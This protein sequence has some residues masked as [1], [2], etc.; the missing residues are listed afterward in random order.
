[1]SREYLR[2]WNATKK[3]KGELY[4][5][6]A[7]ILP[8]DREPKPGRKLKKMT[9]SY[10]VKELGDDTSARNPITGGCGQFT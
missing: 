3:R 1:M 10:P 8:N 6:Q 9:G 7:G 2:Q 5:P 4:K